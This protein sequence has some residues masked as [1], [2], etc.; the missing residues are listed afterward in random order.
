[1]KIKVSK[2]A[3]WLSAISV[4]VVCTALLAQK[5]ESDG[6]IRT[7]SVLG[8]YN[9]VRPIDVNV[10]DFG[11]LAPPCSDRD[12]RIEHMKIDIQCDGITP[13]E[14]GFNCLDCIE[15][16]DHASF[17]IRHIPRF[18]TNGGKSLWLDPATTVTPGGQARQH[19]IVWVPDSIV[20][21]LSVGDKIGAFFC[22]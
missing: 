16:G 4:L 12:R 20:N 2:I 22:N 14:L 15:L 17:I 13:D 3:G 6:M 5:K 11:S 10:K 1:M 9:I 8:N 19:T 18:S 21:K 7:E